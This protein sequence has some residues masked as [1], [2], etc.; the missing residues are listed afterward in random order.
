MT[1]ARISISV[2]IK[3]IAGLSSEKEVRTGNEQENVRVRIFSTHTALR[4][5]C[6]VI[7]TVRW[8]F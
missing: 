1:R 4:S 8:I 6:I 7:Q 5:I 3:T 2:V